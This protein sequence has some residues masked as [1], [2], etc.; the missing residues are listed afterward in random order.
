VTQV[1]DFFV[2][3]QDE[4]AMHVNWMWLEKGKSRRCGCGYWFQLVDAKPLPNCPEFKAIPAAGA[5]H[6]H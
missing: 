3:F 2:L 5:E 4:E 6:H 1:T